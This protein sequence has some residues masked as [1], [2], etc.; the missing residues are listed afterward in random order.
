MILVVVVVI[1]VIPKRVQ[2]RPV[3]SFGNGFRK[4]TPSEEVNG[5]CFRT[6]KVAQSYYSVV[7]DVDWPN[8]SCNT[9]SSMMRQAHDHFPLPEQNAAPPNVDNV[10]AILPTMKKNSKDFG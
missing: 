7:V 1:V 8:I 6:V 3:S 10:F 2:L 4:E 9:L 5:G